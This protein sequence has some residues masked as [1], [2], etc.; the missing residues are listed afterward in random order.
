MSDGIVRDACPHPSA[1]LQVLGVWFGPQMLT[2]THTQRYMQTDRQTDSSWLAI[3]SVEL[4]TKV[5]KRWSDE[6]N[7]DKRDRTKRSR[8]LQT[9]EFSA[10][11]ER[12]TLSLQSANWDTDRHR[13]AR[14]WC[15]RSSLHWRRAV[16]PRRVGSSSRRTPASH[17]ACRPAHRH[18]MSVSSLRHAGNRTYTL[19]RLTHPDTRSVM[20]MSRP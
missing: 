17:H 9:G 4:K 18:D 5:Y 14:C 16:R 12:R 3:L 8:R 7:I 19:C 2:Q 20:I 11:Y 10:H 6:I 1:G 13:P 15:S